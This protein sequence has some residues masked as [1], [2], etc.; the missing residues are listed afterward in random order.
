MEP[1][2][3]VASD[4]RRRVATIVS[5]IAMLTPLFVFASPDPLR[6]LAIIAA[7]SAFIGFVVWRA[8]RRRVR[9]LDE[10]DVVACYRRD[11]ERQIVSIRRGPFVVGAW[12]VMLAIHMAPAHVVVFGGVALVWAGAVA[13]TW[14][15]RKPRIERELAALPA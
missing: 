10:G 4:H 15:G 3:F 7:A 6:V 2:A 8:Y 11:L 5:V 12:L 14:L 9:A 1:K 13:Y